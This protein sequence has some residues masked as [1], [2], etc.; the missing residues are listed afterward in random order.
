MLLERSL[1]AGKIDATRVLLLRRE[2]IDGQREAIEALE[3]L[4]SARARLALAAGA[5]DVLEGQLPASE[6]NGERR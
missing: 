4:W 5:P 1:E 6:I 3:E 2:L